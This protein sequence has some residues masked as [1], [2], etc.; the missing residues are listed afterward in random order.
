VRAVK[1]VAPAFLLELLPYRALRVH[2]SA[3]WRSFLRNFFSYVICS[4]RH[5]LR[6]RL[7]QLTPRNAE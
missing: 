1:I 2:G 3:S 4:L 6:R 5:D 7:I